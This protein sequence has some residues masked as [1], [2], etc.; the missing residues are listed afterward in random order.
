MTQI[1]RSPHSSDEFQ[2]RLTERQQREQ[3]FYKLQSSFEQAKNIDLDNDANWNEWNPDHHVCQLAERRHVGA[4]QRV[5]DI[6]CGAGTMSVRLARMGYN[7]EGIDICDNNI[8]LARTLADRYDVTGR[9]RFRKM[10]A[11]HLDYPDGHFDMVVGMNI[12]AHV[13]VPDA[14]SEV[15]RVLKLG[16]AAVFKESVHVPVV[17][18]LRNTSIAQSILP[19]RDEQPRDH[20][21][22][23][24]EDVQI[25]ESLFDHVESRRFTVFSRFDRLIPGR[26]KAMRRALE[27]VDQTLLRACPPLAH[28]GGTAVI[29]GYKWTDPGADQATQ[30]R[31]AA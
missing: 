7:V 19:H 5:L 2:R 25:I 27:R 26:G 29:A 10:V 23:N 3:S 11:E 22:I 24:G 21:Q 31:I 14:A 30:Y 12:L 13:E 8:L 4:H 18:P 6:G 9:C 16:G 17:D 20:R 15:W 28:L 1:P